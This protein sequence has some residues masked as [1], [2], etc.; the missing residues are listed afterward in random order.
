MQSG[1]SAATEAQN[2]T[3]SVYV[4][5]D[6]STQTVLMLDLVDKALHKKCGDESGRVKNICQWLNK[7]RNWSRTVITEKY[8]STDKW[9]IMY[10]YNHKDY[11]KAKPQKRTAAAVDLTTKQNYY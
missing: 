5:Y 7:N 4:Y 10:K 11:D 3:K 2:P 9:I 1:P 8:F 6:P